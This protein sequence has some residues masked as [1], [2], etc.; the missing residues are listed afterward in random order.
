MRATREKTSQQPVQ[1]TE[2]LRKD[3]NFV[4]FIGS[5]F[6]AGSVLSITTTIVNQAVNPEWVTDYG[7]GASVIGAGLAAYSLSNAS[8]LGRERQTSE[9][10]QAMP[11]VV[12]PNI[13]SAQQ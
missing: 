4:R 12:P 10:L 1:H 9:I 3:E 7:I 8:R 13:T 2:R 6:V 5:M 11:S